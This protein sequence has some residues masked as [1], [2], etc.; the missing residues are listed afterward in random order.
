MKEIRPQS[1]IDDALAVPSFEN[2][3]QVEAQSDA[4]RAS[5]ALNYYCRTA[6]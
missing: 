2:A 4:G 3:D 6:A 1:A 5:P